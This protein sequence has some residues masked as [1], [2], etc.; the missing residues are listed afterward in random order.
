MTESIIQ[1]EPFLKDFCRFDI[2]L[3]EIHSNV[4]LSLITVSAFEC[5]SKVSYYVLSSFLYF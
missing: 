1:P 4:F 2:V 3:L 5:E